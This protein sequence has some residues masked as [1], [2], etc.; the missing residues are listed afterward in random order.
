MRK[1]FT[2][3]TAC[4]VASLV[5]TVQAAEVA[6]YAFES[7]LS[8]SATADGAQDLTLFGDAVLTSPG[9][10][11]EG[12]LSFDGSGDYATATGTNGFTSGVPAITLSTWFTTTTIMSNTQQVL[13]HIP[14]QGG[15][16]TQAAAGM[17]IMAG[18]LQVGGRSVSTEGFKSND[19]TLPSNELLLNSATT[20]FAAAV[21]NYANDTVT[22]YLYNGT[23]WK[24][25]SV[26]HDFANSL[27]TGNQGLTLGRRTDGQRPFN[28]SMDDTRIF[29]HAL[30]EAQLQDLA[31]YDAP[32]TS[33]GDFDDD[34][35]V[36]GRDFLLWQRGQSPSSLSPE[37]LAIWAENYGTIPGLT[38]VTAIPEPGSAALALA[39]GLAVASSRRR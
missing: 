34:G 25:Q 16:T 33:N 1:I 23:E 27:G 17:E 37:D 3:L 13:I 5:T 32:P 2:M 31:G 22:A 7:T 4:L 6:H 38:S 8:D 24:S 18:K 39:L 14:I 20:Y 36:D 15:T 29:T 28:G 21:I 35:D 10:V 26:V 9:I 12:K 11:G 19:A 30:S